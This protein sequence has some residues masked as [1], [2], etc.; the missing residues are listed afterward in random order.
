MATLIW[1][2]D[3]QG[4]AQVTHATPANVET[5]DIFTLTVNRKDVSYTATAATVSNVVNGLVAAW[6]AATASEFDEVTASAGTT[7]GAVTHVVLTGSSDGKP[8][9]VTASTTNA[10]TLG[11]SITTVTD[12]VAATNEEQRVSL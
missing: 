3:A 11:V 8:F 4:R 10:G 5:G 9:T 12:G 2:G 1:R 6:S 7:S